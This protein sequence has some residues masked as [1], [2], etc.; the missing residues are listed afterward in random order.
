MN[1]L[2]ELW[3]LISGAEREN[4]LSPRTL[5]DLEPQHLE[6]RRMTTVI[7]HGERVTYD[8]NSQYCDGDG[9]VWSYNTDAIYERYRDNPSGGNDNPNSAPMGWVG[10]KGKK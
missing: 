9:K 2:A 6:R 5:E 7:R 10:Q 4:K 3:L 1:F 8:A